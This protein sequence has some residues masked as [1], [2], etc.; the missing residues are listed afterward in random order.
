MACNKEFCKDYIE[1]KP[2]E[3]SFCD[4]FRIFC[5]CE[6]EKRDFFDAPGT[7]R[8]KGF[9]RRWIIFASVAVQKF[10]LCFRKP[11]NSFG[12]KIELWSNYPSCNGGLLQLFFNIIQ[13]KTEKPDMKSKKFTSIIGKIDW[14]LNLDK[15]IKMEDNRYVPSLSVMAAKLS[16]E[17]EAFSKKVITENWKMDFI[18]LY[19]FW[20]AYQENYSTQAIMFQDK[21]EDSNLVVVAFRGTIPYD[22]DDW[23]TDV[24]LSWYELEGVGKLHAGFM[25]ALGLQKNTGWPKEIDESPYQ[26]LFAYYEIRKELKRILTKNE[27]A[28]FILTG[29]SLGGALAILF[30]AILSLHEEEWLLDKLEGVYT[31]GQPRVGDVQFGNFMKDKFNKYNVKYYRHVY[32]ND[33]VPRL[34]FDDTALFFKHFGSCVYYNSLYQGKVVEE[35]PNK[36]YFSLLWFF[37]MV[38]IAA[39]EVI[40]GF[41]LPWRKGREYREDWFQTMFRMVGLVIPGLS[42]HTTIDYVNLTRLGS[43]LHN[44]QSAHQEGAKY[45]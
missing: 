20:N 9:R 16:Y 17:N 34:P 15:N 6:L 37:P 32:S 42:A 26:K 12:S 45:D 3:A 18:K 23:I 27:K 4:F 10:L 41:I 11:M 30:A 25:K 43:V 38:L 7:D 29:H 2:E 35:E 22:A 19:N 40:R 14:R 1:L 36:N 21:I 24:D 5:S 8:I 44:P 28:K 39:Y 31:F 33:M 13:G